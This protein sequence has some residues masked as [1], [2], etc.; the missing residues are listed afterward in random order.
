MNLVTSMLATPP[1]RETPG[2][3]PV[4]R[5][6]ALADG[7]PSVTV[8]LPA[9]NESAIVEKSL[10]VVHAYLQT[11]AA[12]YR[13]EILLINDGSDDDTGAI[14]EAFAQSHASVRVLHHPVNFGMGQALITAFKNCHADYVV[15]LDLD[16]SFAPQHIPAM[17]ERM[18]ATSAK[19][20]IA[21][22]YAKGGKITHIPWHRK[23][24][25][26]W[27][28]RFL[29]GAAHGELSSLTG[30]MRAYDGRFLRSLNLK[31]LGMGVNPEIIY[32]AMVLRAR[33]EEI[34]GHLDW[35]FESIGGVERKSSMR[36]ARQILAVLM[37]GFLFR[38]FLFFVV[39]GLALLVFSIYVNAWMLIH[40]LEQYARLAQDTWFLDR[41]SHAVAGAFNQF[42][43]TFVVGGFSLM[44]AIQLL[45]LGLMALQNKKYFEE[46]FHLGTAIYQSS[47]KDPA[48]D[49]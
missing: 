18:R 29:S 35:S 22:P 27:A 5:K 21:S 20:V 43:H 13:C 48:T 11:L 7:R 2:D 38:P 30:I 40:F 32:K 41:A 4:A 47:R 45:S 12:D 39:P 16:L 15:T 8:V 10:S 49:A 6:A 42:P 19:I 33:I 14:A 31:S 36:I 3:N 28:N 26:I 46:I 24:L 44:L 9:F 1:S 25:S 34:P 37:S 17:L 23:T